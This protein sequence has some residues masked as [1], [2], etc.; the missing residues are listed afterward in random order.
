MK[1]GH[2]IA[3][4]LLLRPESYRKKTLERIKFSVY[5]KGLIFI[6]RSK[7]ISSRLRYSGVIETES[8]SQTACDV[9]KEMPHARFLKRMINF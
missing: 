2:F 9:F 8:N 6:V 1:K 7:F 3:N 4:K 5:Y